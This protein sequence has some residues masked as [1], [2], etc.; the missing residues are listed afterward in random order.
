[1]D[2][3]RRW[4]REQGKASLEGHRAGVEKL[5][6][7][8]RWAKEGGIKN[9]IVFAFSTENWDREKGEVSYLMNLFRTVL[10]KELAYFK[11]QGVRVRCVGERGR[12]DTDLQK[13]MTEAEEETGAANGSTLAIALSYGGR[14]EIVNAVNTAIAKGEKV[15]E[16]TFAK[17]LWTDGVPDPDIIIRTG[18]EQ[19]LS[20]FLPW[21][22]VYSELFFTKTKW[23]AFSREEFFS[24]LDEFANRKRNFGK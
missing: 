19:R 10:S 17:H 6:E 4:A 12:F 8:L 23:P 3:N 11:E 2:G 7:A 13:L 9:V 20:G 16:K 18:G 24:I 1:M 14:A 21:Q 15:D 5:K 22:G